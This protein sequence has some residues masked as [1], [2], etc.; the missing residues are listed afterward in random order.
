MLS[1][2]DVWQTLHTAWVNLDFIWP[3]MMTFLPLPFII[4]LILKPAPQTQVPL[5]APHLVQQ[6]MP[7]LKQSNLIQP[8][9]H[10]HKMPWFALLLWLLVIVAAMRPIWYLSPT[11]FQQTGKNL[12]LAVD[13]SGSM[14]KPDMR[15]GGHHVDRLTAVKSVVKQFI[16]QRQGDRM[17]LV[18]FGT[19]AFIQSPLT[20]DLSTLARL[21]DETQIGMAGNHTA[22][23]DA[24][25]LTLKHLAQLGGQQNRAV[26]ILL[27]D[28]SNTAGVVSPLEAAEKAKQMGLKIYTIGVG[29]VS[30]SALGG[31]IQASGEMD[32]KTLQKIA[33][34]TGGQ[35]FLASDVQ[36]LQ[37]VYQ[38]INQLEATPYQLNQ[39]RLRTE[40]YAWPLGLALLMS[41][42]WAFWRLFK[43]ARLA[44]SPQRRDQ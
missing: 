43:H 8:E 33:Q 39:Y 17:A 11:P 7:V 5:Y 16:H 44:F 22:I 12:I 40:L 2:M 30:H 4:R 10:T 42:G 25:G 14:E 23:G 27:T 15:L 31:L 38:L 20:Y 18:V 13:L 41:F 9:A 32:V 1:F 29:Q 24:I 37:K 26:L 6:L 28:G 19:Q 3:W 34:I 35:F 21:L 36:Q